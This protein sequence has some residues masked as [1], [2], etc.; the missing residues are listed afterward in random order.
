M[1]A[2]IF[3][4]GNIN[5]IVFL[6]LMQGIPEFV[7]FFSPSG[8][9]FSKEYLSKYE[10]DKIQVSIISSE[11]EMTLGM[12]KLH[13]VFSIEVLPDIINLLQTKDLNQLHLP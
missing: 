10:L 12:M 2:S 1:H 11:F 13:A 6:F 3:E 4:K 9:R 5:T 7:V 8:V